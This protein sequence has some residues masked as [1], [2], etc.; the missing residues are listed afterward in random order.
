MKAILCLVTLLCL[1]TVSPLLA[2]GEDSTTVST[3][4][5]PAENPADDTSE[6][7][8]MAY[9]I[10]A[11]AI[12][13]MVC[14]GAGAVLA[15]AVLLL[16]FALVS[17]GVLSTAVVSGLYH[18]SWSK[19]FRTLVVMCSAIASMIAGAIVFFFITQLFQWCTP[20]TS[21]ITGGLAGLAGGLVL[22]KM[23]CLILRRL[24]AYFRQ[25]LNLV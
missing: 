23:I 19:G 18:R 14:V 15:T 17:A 25:K 24:L 11:G 8:F 21:I 20:A 1:F 2:Q 3:I 9:L 10:I 22:G 5:T 12:F 6:G 7:I 4:P 13:V 16:L